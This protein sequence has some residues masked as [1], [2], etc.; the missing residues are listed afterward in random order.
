MSTRNAFTV[1]IKRRNASGDI[2]T[3]V[4][5]MLEL[6][7]NEVRQCMQ[8]AGGKSKKSNVQE[9]DTA[10]EG[11]R[12]SVIK[13]DNKKLTHDDLDGNKWD[14]HFSTRET[15]LLTKAWS[16]IHIPDDEELEAVMGNLEAHS[17]SGGTE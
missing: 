16:K 1:P 4:I 6:R 17:V 13:I 10:I 3:A 14:D 9:W 2:V 11:L 5:V 7:P 15:M 12:R 8:L